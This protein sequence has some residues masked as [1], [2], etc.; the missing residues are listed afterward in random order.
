[1]KK[2]VINL[3]KPDWKSTVHAGSREILLKGAPY[4]DMEQ[5][6]VQAVA[7][8]WPDD[9]GDAAQLHQF[10]QRYSGFYSLVCSLPGQLIASVDRIRSNPL[11]YGVANSQF[12]LSDNAEWVRQ[13][14]GDEVMDPVARE[15]L[16]LV[17]YVTGQDT[18]FPH[19]KQLQAGECLIAEQSGGEVNVRCQRYCRYLHTEPRQYDEQALQQQF[20]HMVDKVI[21]RLID[22]AAGRQ[23]VVPLSGGYDSRLV[24]T[25][26][27]RLGYNNVLTFTYGVAG[28][29]DSQ[30]SKQVADTLGFKWH[31]VEYTPELWRNT[32]ESPEG[33]RYQ[34]WASGWGSLAHEQDW[35]AV[36]MMKQEGVV[37]ADAVFAP[38]HIVI[39]QIGGRYAPVETLRKLILTQTGTATE[40]YKHHYYLAPQNVSTRPPHFWQKRITSRIADH[41]GADNVNSPI[42]F[43]CDYEEWGWQERQAKYTVNS[44]RVY[45]FFNYDWWLPFWDKDFFEFW[46]E[47][48]FALRKGREWYVNY[49]K[50]QYALQT[51]AKETTML[52][53][54]CES[55]LR[56]AIG[57]LVKKLPHFV[58]NIHVGLPKRVRIAQMIKED[59]SA[60]AQ[61]GMFPRPKTKWLLKN[62]YTR[63][64]I[65]AYFFFES[66]K[67]NVECRPALPT[68]H[69]SANSTKPANDKLTAIN[70]SIGWE[71]HL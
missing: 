28:N 31:F 38:G 42:S 46:R 20:D 70:G 2:I 13:Q 17:G 48:P 29:K 14:V 9:W 23:I 4:L 25:K 50:A 22:Y 40:L 6:T 69:G 67:L 51:G 24:V 71:N 36:K 32:W 55:R 1:M 15:E 64:G 7:N 10:L 66:I 54:A 33:W 12:Y 18:L 60:L 52:G 65:F 56:I 5:Q 8:D 58:W 61:I 26:L 59:A 68:T 45:E 57:T 62:G 41:E 34:S 39:S 19:V 43:D 16:Q 27:K 3:P 21:R 35:P 11:F 49:S 44:V 53:N 37:S 47:A 63:Y 30:Y